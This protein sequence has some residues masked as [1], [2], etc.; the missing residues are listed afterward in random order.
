M[1]DHHSTVLFVEGR[2]EAD[3]RTWRSL[4][5]R[6]RKLLKDVR[7]AGRRVDQVSE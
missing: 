2:D 4:V 7:R 5:R 1:K 6:L 3:E